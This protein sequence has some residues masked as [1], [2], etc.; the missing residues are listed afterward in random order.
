ME[1]KIS[2]SSHIVISN[3]NAAFKGMF[4]SNAIISINIP[5]VCGSAIMFESICQHCNSLYKYW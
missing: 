5:R 2:S 1:Q 4:T 3:A